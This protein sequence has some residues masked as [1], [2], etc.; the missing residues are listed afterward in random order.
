MEDATLTTSWHSYPKLFALG[1]RSIKDIFLDPVLVEEKLDGSQFSFGIFDGELRCRS[2]G[3][4]LNMLAPE[5]MFQPAVDFVTTAA[6]KLKNGW[7]YRGEFLG[8]PKHNVLAYGRAPQNFIMGF[9][10]NTGHEEYMSYE[11]K[12]E[13]FA[14]IGLET[15]PLIYRGKINSVDVFRAFLGRESILGGQKVEGA[16]VKNYSRF[17]LDGKAFMGKFVSEAFKEIHAS[18]WKERHP[19]NADIL[20]ILIQKYRTPARWAKAVQHLR[21]AGKLEGSPRDIGPVMKEA[22]ADLLIECSEQ[23]KDELFQ[24]AIA[25]IQRGTVAGIAEWYK[26]ELLKASFEGA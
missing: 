25:K 8:R 16:V 13:E 5:K 3:A 4:V 14:A 21:E 10:I 11:Q 2:K 20:E 18:D 12:V 19:S 9:D 6:N 7:T 15:V 24:H 23:I 1:H 22:A 26:E 17:G